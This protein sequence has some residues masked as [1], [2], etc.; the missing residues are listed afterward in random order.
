MGSLLVQARSIG[1]IIAM[2][3]AKGEYGLISEPFK[4][5]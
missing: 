4:A 2:V 1:I 3:E 5:S